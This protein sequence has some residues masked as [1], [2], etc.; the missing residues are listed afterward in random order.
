MSVA[1]W[2]GAI[3]AMTVAAVA[4]SHSPATSAD[5]AADGAAEFKA[6]CAACHGQ[7][8]RGTGKAPGLA[9]NPRLAGQTAPQLEPVIRRGF[10]ASG[11]PPVNL[12]REE[13]NAV[14]S[15]V[16]ELNANLKA[17]PRST[18]RRVVWGKPQPGDWLTYNGSLSAN[19][20]SPLKQINVA[21][22]AGLK[23]KWLFPI[24]YFGLEVTPLAA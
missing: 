19:R 6:H 12:P 9:A 13:L 15:Y 22:V 10:P 7:D 4:M 24:P 17:A 23:L 2:R 18:G 11:M 3:F 8:A 1:A 5:D 21:N 20:Y 16:A 14:A